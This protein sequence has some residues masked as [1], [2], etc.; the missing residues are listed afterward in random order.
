MPIEVYIR[1]GE[2]SAVY[3]GLIIRHSSDVFRPFPSVGAASSMCMYSVGGADVFPKQL[4]TIFATI[5]VS[6]RAAYRSAARTM[7]LCRGAHSSRPSRSSRSLVALSSCSDVTRQAA[8]G[9]G[10][11]SKIMPIRSLLRVSL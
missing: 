6:I 5:T 8:Y 1:C 11:S 4:W 3:F 10:L 9:T 7:S 2:L